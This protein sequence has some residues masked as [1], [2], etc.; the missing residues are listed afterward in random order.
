MCAYRIL[1]EIFIISS[2]YFSPGLC[3]S[4][5]LRPIPDVPGQPLRIHLHDGG[6]DP[7]EIPGG[8]EAK[9][10]AVKMLRFLYDL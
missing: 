1:V 9:P 3:L 7:G 10:T 2:A 6:H 8:H 4:L 5:R